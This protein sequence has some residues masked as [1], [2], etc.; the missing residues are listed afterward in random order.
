MSAVI[1]FQNV[2]PSPSLGASSRAP[3]SPGI[4]RLCPEAADRRGADG[5]RAAG[6]ARERRSAGCDRRLRRADP[7]DDAR[8]PR[9]PRRCRRAP[10]RPR[11]TVGVAR[12]PDV[13]IPPSAGVAVPRRAAA[14]L[15]RRAVHL[16]VDPRLREPVSP[17]GAVSARRRDRDPRPA[18]RRLPPLRTVRPVPLHDGARHRPRRKSGAR[19]RAARRRGPLQDRRPLPRRRGGPLGI[20]RVLRR[21]ARD[22][23]GDGQVRPRQQ[24][25]L[26]RAEDGERKLHPQR[27]RP[28]PAPGGFAARTSR[29]RGSSRRERHVPRVQPARPCALRSA[30][31]AGDRLCDRSGDDR[32]DDLEGARRSR[33]IDP[34]PRVV[35]A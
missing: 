12:S 14:H 9:P 8:L 16:H 10:P 2:L 34:S 29:R 26:P 7:P 4:S 5:D 28:R 27:G 33:R 21:S 17:P 35:G 15:R 25:A 13:Y 19:L 18:D 24:R 3:L 31:A 22:P 11:A 30:S 20:R 6:G 23:R 32:P 1:G